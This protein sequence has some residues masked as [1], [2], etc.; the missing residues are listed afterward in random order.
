MK[1]LLMVIVALSII[2]AFIAGYTMQRSEKTQYVPGPTITAEAYGESLNFELVGSDTR[3]RMV[4]RETK[5]DVMYFVYASS[6]GGG[7]GLTVMYD[8]QTGGPL[9]YTNW[10]NNY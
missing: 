8:P 4:F 10:K 1:K 3:T 7:V 2:G 5:T 6:S 9:T